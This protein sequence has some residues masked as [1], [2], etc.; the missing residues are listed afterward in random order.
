MLPSDVSVADLLLQ[1][2]RNDTSH[3]YRP[4][5]GVRLSDA[6]LAIERINRRIAGVVFQ[7]NRPH[8]T[9]ESLTLQSLKILPD[10]LRVG[11]HVAAADARL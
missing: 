11:A 3:G 10:A 6:K 5:H 1:G 4:L 2:R 8:L 7:A 9:G